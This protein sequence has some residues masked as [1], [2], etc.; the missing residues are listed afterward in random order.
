MMLNKLISALTW[1]NEHP[2]GA[3]CHLCPMFKDDYRPCTNRGEMAVIDFL[4]SY[5][6]LLEENKSW[7][8]RVRWCDEDIKAALRDLDYSDCDKNVSIIRE[9]CMHHCFRE[10][11]EE[12]GWHYITSYIEENADI[13]EVNC[14]RP[15]KN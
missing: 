4:G 13:L 10:A 14:E 9:Q 15:K 7:F 12:T 1:C 5:A 3:D 8:G 6:D 11:M 2:D